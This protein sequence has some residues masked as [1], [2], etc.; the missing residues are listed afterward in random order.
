MSIVIKRFD[1]TINRFFLMVLL[2]LT[3]DGDV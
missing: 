3:L 1:C 2:K